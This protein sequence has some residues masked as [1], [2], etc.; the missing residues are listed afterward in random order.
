MARWTDQSSGGTRDVVYSP[1]ASERRHAGEDGWTR[2][3]LDRIQGDRWE[4]TE[5]LWVAEEAVTI[6]SASIKEIDTE[7][8]SAIEPDADVHNI[9]D[10]QLT[11]RLL[12]LLMQVRPVTI[13]GRSTTSEPDIVSLCQCERHMEGQEGQLGQGSHFKVRLIAYGYCSWWWTT[14]PGGY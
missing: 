2:L 1:Q 9:T 14:C 7:S 4:G 6:D 10:N 12:Q 8:N 3:R 13:S 5:D 11:T